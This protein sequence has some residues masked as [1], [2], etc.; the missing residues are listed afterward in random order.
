MKTVL[1]RRGV[2]ASA[3]SVAVLLGTSKCA[4]ARNA[5]DTITNGIG[6]EFRLIPA[7]SFLMGSPDSDRE[8]RDFEKPQHRVTISRPFYL[9]RHEVTQAQWEAV[10]GSNPYT[11]DR[12]NPYYGLPGMAERIT[13]PDHPAT[14]SWNDAQR[15]IARLNEREGGNRY[16]LPT[17][18]EWEYAARA[19]TTTAYSFGDNAVELGRYAWYGED[20]ATGGTHPVGRKAPNP[21]GLYDIH[22]NAWEWVRDWYDPAYYA[23]SPATDPQGPEQGGERVV[24][25]GSWHTTATSWRTAF[26]RSYVPDYRGISIGFRLLRTAE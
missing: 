1:N 19:G 24:R 4:L 20:F 16:R 7:G 18:A 15:F 21:W 23:N 22:G 3:A 5:V 2:L 14:V 8:A 26:R 9:A 6:M 25:G 13:R 11:L 17:E 12:S 10:M